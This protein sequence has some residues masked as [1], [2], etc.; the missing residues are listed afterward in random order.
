MKARLIKILLGLLGVILIGGG[1]LWATFGLPEFIEIDGMEIIGKEGD[2]VKARVNARIYNPNFYSL[3]A[4]E[5]TYIIAYR[6]TVLGQGELAEME[7][8]GGD[9]TLVELDAVM[10]LNGI[11][12]VYKTM[13]AQP[14]CTMQ[15]H[16]DGKFTSLNYRES[17]QIENIVAPG[18]LLK[19]LLGQ[20]M[21]GNSLEFKELQWKPKS[22][23][24][25]GFKFMAEFRNPAPLPFTI[26]A[27]RMEFS[28]EGYGNGKTG[29]WALDEPIDVQPVGVVRIP[30]DVEVE[31]LK[32]G[33]DL[34]TGMF[35]GEV[36]Y[37]SVGTL[38]LSLEGFDFEIPIQG[39]FI[40][41][42]KTQEGRW[43]TEGA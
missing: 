6:D 1:I 37:F 4:K 16:L 10:D 29:E 20:M 12:S 41:D 28:R 24:K 8:P 19:Q 43:E 25:S 2:D 5:L 35:K 22:V 17:L 26:K 31:N 39:K 21:D 11:F 33:A 13:L 18:D 7:L 42:L 27:L 15:V 23:K 30:G 14:K 38:V 9:T 3:G 36:K 34:F 40:F 32:A